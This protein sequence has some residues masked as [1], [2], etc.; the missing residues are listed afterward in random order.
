M[1]HWSAFVFLL[2]LFVLL[3]HAAFAVEGQAALAQAL[4]QGDLTRAFA[5]SHKL[6]G[7]DSSSILTMLSS[8]AW[9]GD[10]IAF[11]IILPHLPDSDVSAAL[12]SV[13]RPELIEKLH[14]KSNS[15]NLADEVLYRGF[16]NPFVKKNAATLQ[17]VFEKV[18]S[19]AYLEVKSQ[20]VREFVFA[21]AN[22]TALSKD[23]VY[24]ESSLKIAK[25]WHFIREEQRQVMDRLTEVYPSVVGSII[26]G[27]IY[28][29]ASEFQNIADFSDAEPTKGSTNASRFRLD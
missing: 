12:T 14:Q 23:G 13:D 26:L 18:L 25:E 21:G 7:V 4:A 28:P 2:Q 20:L 5:E 29:Y 24:N 10:T 16:L 3:V 27:Y 1:C 9:T 19:P 11:D 17:A 15:I 6:T 22:V 8:A